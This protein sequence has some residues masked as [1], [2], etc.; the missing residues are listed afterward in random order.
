MGARTGAEFLAGLQATKRAL[1]ID[2][3]QIDDPTTHPV[4]RGAAHTLASIFDRQ[5]A[6][7]D[8]C[9]VP[10][11]ETGEPINISHQIPRSHDD[12][13]RR[14]QGLTRLSEGTVGL[15][16]RTPDYMNMKFSAFAASPSVWAGPEGVNAK[17]AANLVAYQKRLAR[18]DILVALQNRLQMADWFARH[19]EIGEQAVARPLF[20]TGLPRS[21]T[22]ILHELLAQD[23]AHRAPRHWEV[24][25][26]CP[27]PERASYQSDPRIGLADQEIQLWNQIVPSNQGVT[28][29]LDTLIPERFASSGGRLV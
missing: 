2:G 23:P 18:Q 6:F 20:I 15:M 5:H 3:E 12:L 24:R 28:V 25:Y 13:V 9:L 19:P 29:I 1:W 26:P 8:E 21:G 22:S 4:T 16:G 14:N 7:A 17:G 11:P 10:D 27:P